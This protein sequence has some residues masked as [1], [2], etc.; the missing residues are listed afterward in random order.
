MDGGTEGTKYNS[1]H[2]QLQPELRWL[3]RELQSGQAW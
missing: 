3:E 2:A 1:V